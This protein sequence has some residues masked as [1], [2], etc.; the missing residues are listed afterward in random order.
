MLPFRYALIGAAFTLAA[1]AAP[2]GDSATTR[3]DSFQ[4]TAAG[5]SLADFDR[6][7]LVPV[8]ASSDVEARVDARPLGRRGSGDVRPLS[9]DDINSKAED[10]EGLL[11]RELE[12]VVALVDRPGPG[13]LTIDVVLT[14]LQASR[15]TIA[16]I[17][18]EPGLSL[19]SVYAGG[20]AVEITFRE[21]PSTLATARDGEMFDLVNDPKV[22]IW[23]DADRYFRFLANKVA[24]LFAE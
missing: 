23:Q 5:I 14:D 11:R 20:A 17:G 21:G 1:C 19:R 18:A 15:P 22:G 16:E 13:I 2:S 24:A 7:F 8:T 9:R 3:F 6:V 12:E 4:P 10:L